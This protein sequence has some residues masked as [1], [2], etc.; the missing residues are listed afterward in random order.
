MSQAYNFAYTDR[1]AAVFVSLNPATV[2]TLE[3]VLEDATVTMPSPTVATH[4]VSLG[5]TP[6]AAS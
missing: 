1:F 6:A 3:I 5:Y 2:D 4:K